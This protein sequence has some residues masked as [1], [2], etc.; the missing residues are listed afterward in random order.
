MIRHNHAYIDTNTKMHRRKGNDS[1]VHC[2][3]CVLGCDSFCDNSNLFGALKYTSAIIFTHVS[4][5]LARKFSASAVQ[6]S[7]DQR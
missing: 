2:T 4:C 6:V 1:Y 5:I 7:K 3:Q